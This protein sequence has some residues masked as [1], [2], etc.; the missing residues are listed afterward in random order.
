MTHRCHT[1]VTHSTIISHAAQPGAHI[2]T[3]G[4]TPKQRRSKHE[5]KRAQ[6]SVK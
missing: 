6:A 3:A 1:A 5:V 4:H 2:S